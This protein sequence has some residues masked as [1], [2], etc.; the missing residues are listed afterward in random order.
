MKAE[1]RKGCPQR[2]GVE[3]KEYA[4]AQSFSARESKERGGAND[5]LERIL[6]RENLNRAYK[7]V[8]RNH[9]APGIDGMT[10]EKALLWIRENR[11]ELLQSIREGSY[12]P[13]PVRR[14]EIPKPD[15]GV[16]KLG[17]PT[18]VD[19]VIQQAIAQKLQPIYEPLF[20]DGSYGY[21]PKR[22]AQQ[23][24]QKVKNYTEQGYGYAVEIDLSKY[25]DTLNHEL[26]LNLLRRQIHDER[27]TLL[28]K[29]YLKSGV[30]EG[31]TFTRTEEGSPQ[32]GPLSPLLSNVYL[33]RKS[34][35]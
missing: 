17:I 30:M 33:D 34:V 25:F 2:D 35:V 6:E 4:G 23:A 8:K 28:I 27:V 9:G 16:R 29:K 15:G 11:E 18:V 14:K 1:N 20:S 5:L 7:Q 13:N 22:S 32:G 26:L 19:R 10:V 21:R 24:I 3:R 31:G 12:K